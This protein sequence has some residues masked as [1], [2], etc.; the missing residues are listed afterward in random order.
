M[1]LRR[2]P[3]PGGLAL[4]KFSIFYIWANFLI[5]ILT[6]YGYNKNISSEMNQIYVLRGEWNE[7]SLC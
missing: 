7:R 2:P 4:A 6:E 5:D 1:Q 3:A